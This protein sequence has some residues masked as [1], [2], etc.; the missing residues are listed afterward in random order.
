MIYLK[1]KKNFTILPSNYSHKQIIKEKIDC[2]ITCHGNAA[3]EYSYLGVP[4]IACSN[5]SPYK[6]FDFCI[7]LKSKKDLDYKIQNLKKI[8]KKKIDKIKILDYFFMEFNYIETE[9]CCLIFL[10]VQSL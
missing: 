1:N 9:S 7:F 4:T 3:H 5:V 6:N 8:I 2:M 10:K